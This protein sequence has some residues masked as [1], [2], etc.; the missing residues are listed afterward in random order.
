[1][2]SAM[3]ALPP[4]FFWCDS[5]TGAAM[6]MSSGPAKRSITGSDGKDWKP[7]SEQKRGLTSRYFS[8]DSPSCQTD[9]KCMSPARSSCQASPKS[10]RPAAGEDGHHGMPGASRLTV[11]SIRWFTRS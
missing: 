7:N 8:K 6:F 10:S 4:M 1:M 3:R 11:R 2:V 9:Q 5:I